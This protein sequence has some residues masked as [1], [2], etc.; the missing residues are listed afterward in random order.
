VIGREAFQVP[1]SSADRVR[2]RNRERRWD[3]TAELL[4]RRRSARPAPLTTMIEALKYPIK[5]T[6]PDQE[7]DEPR[8]SAPHATSAQS[9]WRESGRVNAP[10]EL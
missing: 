10:P 7:H 5:R 6:D 3:I 1:S 9:A 2:S 4:G 8:E